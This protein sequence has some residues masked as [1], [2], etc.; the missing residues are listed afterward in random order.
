MVDPIPGFSYL[1]EELKKFKL[2]YLHLVVVSRTSDT[3]H[4]V[5]YVWS[6]S[7]TACPPHYHFISTDET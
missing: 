7:S 4:E 3:T 6:I 5:E 1:L 2:A